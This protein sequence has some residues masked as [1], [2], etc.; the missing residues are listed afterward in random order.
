M[1]KPDLTHTVFPKLLI[2]LHKLYF[3][4][5]QVFMTVRVQIVIFWLQHRQITIFWRSTLFPISGMKQISFLKMEAAYSSGIVLS[6]CRS[7]QY[8]NPETPAIKK[9]CFLGEILQNKLGRCQK[10]R[11]LNMN[12]EE[13][14]CED[15]L[16]WKVAVNTYNGR[17]WKYDDGLNYEKPTDCYFL[18]RKARLF[19]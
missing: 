8:H 17:I 2:Y 15:F 19:Q 10:K 14:R 1:A 7:T 6:T 11:M 9:W 13:W 18:L 5:Y 3:I 12:P 4:S 16:R